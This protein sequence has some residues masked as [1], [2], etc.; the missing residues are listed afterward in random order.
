MNNINADYQI[1]YEE[2]I[3][4]TNGQRKYGGPPEDWIGDPPPRG[5]EIF[6]GGL[7][8][9]FKENSFVPL[10]AKIGRIYST[11]L[12]VDFSGQNRGF[13]FIQYSTTAEAKT[14]IKDLHGYEIKP[15][16]RLH[17]TK[18]IDN[19]RLFVGHIPKTLNK[20]QIEDILRSYFDDIKQVFVYYNPSDKNQNRG[21]CFVEFQDHRAACLA[22][23]K[24]FTT[25]ISEWRGVVVDWAIPEEDVAEE[26]M[27]SVTVM[28]MRNLMLKTSEST[29]RELLLQCVKSCEILRVRK[30]RDFA[31]A[32]F[33]NRNA[34]SNAI[35]FMNGF[36]IDGAEI[37][38]TW[39]KPA[40]A[41]EK[42]NKVIC[43]LYL[44]YFIS[45]LLDYVI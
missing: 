10:F 41:I 20:Q 25:G 1:D 32:H 9:D 6:V 21:F 7:P 24:Y 8:R 34:A 13:A 16:M 40:Y 45:Y 38:A 27:N 22:R 17:V 26:V 19:C 23:R 39:A 15:G 36:N 14:A 35:K 33:T 3:F 12:M 18:S 2:K 43:F 42:V 44:F 4:Q 37:F 29:I 30:V 31:F 28:Y 5:T 11:R